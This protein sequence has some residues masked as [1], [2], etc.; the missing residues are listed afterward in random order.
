MSAAPKRNC[1]HILYQSFDYSSTAA[2]AAAKFSLF[3][4]DSKGLC[5]L[6]VSQNFLFH[7]YREMRF[8]F[9]FSSNNS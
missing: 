9:R 6:F 1:A 3:I 8:Y 5:K 2:C 7:N 4:R